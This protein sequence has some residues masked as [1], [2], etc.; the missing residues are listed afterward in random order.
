MWS[1]WGKLCVYAWLKSFPFVQLL[2]FQSS[3]VCRRPKTQ[4]CSCARIQ[5][6]W[7]PAAPC[8]PPPPWPGTSLRPSPWG[9]WGPGPY[10]P[11][12][13]EITHTL[14]RTTVRL[15]LTYSIH[16]VIWLWNLSGAAQWSIDNKTNFINTW[17][18]HSTA[19]VL[20]YAGQHNTADKTCD[21][22]EFVPFCDTSLYHNCTFKL[23]DQGPRSTS[24][25]F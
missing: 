5:P 8:G 12:S 1:V 23:R 20:C 13:S 4:L 16:Q 18:G 7:Q 19:T 25:S 9:T 15:R 10:C 17:H 24:S 6:A 14:F 2:T 22:C 3:P 21:F 11:A